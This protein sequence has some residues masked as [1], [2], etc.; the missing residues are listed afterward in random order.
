MP[1]KGVRFFIPIGRQEDIAHCSKDALS[2][3]FD[4]VVRLFPERLNE[5]RKHLSNEQVRSLQQKVENVVRYGTDEDLAWQLF[6]LGFVDLEG[7]NLIDFYNKV[8]PPTLSQ[9]V[10]FRR[11][12]KSF[13]LI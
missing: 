12:L 5:L 11:K 4:D 7:I 6:D 2:S 3:V 8:L 13:V 10:R 9:L 1:W